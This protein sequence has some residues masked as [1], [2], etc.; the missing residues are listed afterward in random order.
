M[1]QNDDGTPMEFHEVVTAIL[2]EEH[3]RTKEDAVGLVKQFP[4]VI[5]TAMMAGAG[6]EYRSAAM[7]LEMRE[8][9]ART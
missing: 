6:K 8:T 2:V 7:A 4:Y 5:I 9:E 1:Y 3:G